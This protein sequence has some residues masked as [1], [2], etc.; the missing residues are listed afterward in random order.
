V[1]RPRAL[2][3]VALLLVFVVVVGVV[4]YANSQKGVQ[5][6]SFDVTVSSASRMSPDTLR[7]TADDTVTIN[8]MSDRDGEV[9]LHV[10]DIAFE[11]KAGQVTSRTF[12]ADKTCTCLIEWEETST[13]LGNLIVSP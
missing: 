11:L 2:I 6:L 13:A 1:S 8:V 7:A 12:K 4:I 5:N 10:Y 9:H 3:L